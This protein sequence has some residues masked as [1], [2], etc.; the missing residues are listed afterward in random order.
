MTEPTYSLCLRCERRVYGT[1]DGFCPACG[2]P[3]MEIEN[4]SEGNPRN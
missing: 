2:D 3:L 1:H 4:Q